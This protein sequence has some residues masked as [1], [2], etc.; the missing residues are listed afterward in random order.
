MT[1]I[2]AALAL[3]ASL[4]APLTA[5][6]QAPAGTVLEETIPPG[7]NYEK[8]EFRL[9]LPNGVPSVQAIAVLVPGSNGDGRG[10]VDDPVWQEFAVRNNRNNL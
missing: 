2:A 3:S 5:S 8:A 10:Q 9:W 7:R 1:N 4:F 6:A